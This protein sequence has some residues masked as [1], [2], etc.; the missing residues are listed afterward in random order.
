MRD[1]GFTASDAR[2]YVALL[3][4]HPATGYE[5][6]ALSG[7]PR[8]AIYNVLRQLETRGLVNAIQGKPAKYVPLSP[9]Q[10]FELLSNRFAKSL[11]QFKDS[12]QQLGNRSSQSTT[13]TFQG[14]ATMLE[15]AQSIIASAKRCVYLSLWKREAELL[16]KPLSQAVQNGVDVVLFSWTGLPEGIGRVF[17]YEVEEKALS[18]Y[19]IHKIILVADQKQAL[20]GGAEQTD[21]NRVVVTEEASLVEMAISNLVLDITLYGQRKG[22][23]TKEV[24]TKLTE[25]LAPVE[26]LMPR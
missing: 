21:H 8:S 19:W 23:D 4:T 20:V 22:L 15:R 11:E 13:W 26:D 3:K 5:L 17:S 10:L 14:Y 12:V 16:A 1:L 9:D 18:K 6:A 2:A 7:V 25:Y 24:V